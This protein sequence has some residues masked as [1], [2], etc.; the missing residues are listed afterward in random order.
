MSAEKMER[1]CLPPSVRTIASG[2]HAASTTEG[3]VV[4]NNAAQPLQSGLTTD[5]E[6]LR[7]DCCSSE[8]DK[9]HFTSS[10]FT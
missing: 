5:I 1:T 6:D 4:E 7:R 8:R 10:L 9:P 2:N 3:F